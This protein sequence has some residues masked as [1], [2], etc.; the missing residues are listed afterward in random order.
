MV[1]A[2]PASVKAANAT[3]A[4]LTDTDNGRYSPPTCVQL[5]A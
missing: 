3:E 5:A 2:G 1:R 4:R